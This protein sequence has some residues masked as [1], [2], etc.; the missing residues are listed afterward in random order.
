MTESNKSNTALMTV[1]GADRAP[2]L[3]EAAAQLGLAEGDLNGAFGVIPID[4]GRQLY[5]V[6]VQ[7]DRLS[8]PAARSETYRGPFSNPEIAPFGPIKSS[9]TETDEG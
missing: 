7:A 6:E 1:T 2:T 3:A 4:P 8:S 5:T 9:E